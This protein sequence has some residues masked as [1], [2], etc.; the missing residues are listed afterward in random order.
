VCPRGIVRGGT[1][2]AMRCATCL[3]TSFLI[4]SPAA[5]VRRMK[6]TEG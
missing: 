2:I 6:I 3:E 1:A 4:A 5:E